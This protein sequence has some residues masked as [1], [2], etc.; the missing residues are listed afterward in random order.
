[1][2]GPKPICGAR[3]YCTCTWCRP[4]GERTEPGG[5]LQPPGWAGGGRKAHHAAGAA[6]APRP[7]HTRGGPGREEQRHTGGV[8]PGD[9]G[10]GGWTRGGVWLCHAP[11]SGLGI[12]L[13]GWDGDNPRVGS[14]IWLSV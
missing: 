3:V 8:P 6:G 10:R 12:Q 1:M 14:R 11:R 7:K 13:K 4:L 9:P 2:E 5:V